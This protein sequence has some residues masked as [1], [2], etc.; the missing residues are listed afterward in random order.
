M[1]KVWK[2]IKLFYI[3]TNYRL[4]IQALLFNLFLFLNVLYE[5]VT[6]QIAKYRDTF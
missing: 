4:Y 3:K 6:A 2:N 5:Q 1:N